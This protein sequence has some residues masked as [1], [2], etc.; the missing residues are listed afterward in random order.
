MQMV[1]TLQH[2]LLMK[3]QTIENQERRMK[4]L[5]AILKRSLQA[6]VHSDE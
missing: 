2:D 6:D 3:S 4:E 5:K 1:E